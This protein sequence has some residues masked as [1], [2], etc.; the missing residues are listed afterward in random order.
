M[1]LQLLPRGPDHWQYYDGKLNHMRA[2]V[3]GVLGRTELTKEGNVSVFLR[4]ER[5]ANG[6]LDWPKGSY[7]CVLE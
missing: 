2:T 1:S 6:A 3:L 4:A 7:V 5:I